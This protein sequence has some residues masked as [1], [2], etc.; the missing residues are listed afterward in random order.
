MRVADMVTSRYD[1]IRLQ[2]VTDEFACD[3]R[4]AQRMMRAFEAVFPQVSVTEDDQRRRRWHLPRSDPRWLQAQGLRDSELA[5]L[6]MAEKR[7]LRDGALE[8]AKNI[9]ASA[10]E[11]YADALRRI[12]FAWRSSRFS[13]SKAFSFSA[14]SVEIL[15]RSPRSTS[16]FLTHLFSVW[17]AHPIFEEIDKIAPLGTLPCNALPCSGPAALMLPGIVQNQANGTLAYVGGTLVRR[18]AHDASS[19]SGVEAS[20]KPGA[21][22]WQVTVSS[23][24][25]AVPR[26]ASRWPV[27]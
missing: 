9:R 21:V 7:A 12:S 15:A 27:A 16:A 24:A 23:Q 14:I 5:A 22:Q 6:E 3:H 20:G 4:T 18:L 8:D 10:I 2:D 19:C 1:G 25:S 26:F 11:K 17:G 13:R